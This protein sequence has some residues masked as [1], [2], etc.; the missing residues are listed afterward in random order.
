MSVVKLSRVQTN[1]AEIESLQR[2]QHGGQDLRK[3]GLCSAGWSHSD[4]K[5]NKPQRKR[6]NEKIEVVVWDLEASQCKP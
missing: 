6:I 4:N 1:T 3:Q 2:V 5:S